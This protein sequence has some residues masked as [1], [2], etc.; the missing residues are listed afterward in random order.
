MSWSLIHTF[1]PFVT[2]QFPRVQ[3]SFHMPMVKIR[4]QWKLL[5]LRYAW[6]CAID[7]VQR[8]IMYSIATHQTSVKGSSDLGST[9]AFLN[10]QKYVNNTF[11]PWPCLSLWCQWLI[12]ACVCRPCNKNSIFE[13]INLWF[14]AKLWN[15]RNFQLIKKE[16]PMVQDSF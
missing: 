1:Y 15:Q 11:F 8:L 13:E 3:I 7:Y 14:S 5:F 6:W 12:I 10:S 4:M 16:C 9:V 2:F